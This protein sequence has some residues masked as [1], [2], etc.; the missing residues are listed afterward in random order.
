MGATEA[1]PNFLQMVDLFFDKAAKRLN[2]PPNLLA[3]IKT[4]NSMI[5]VNFPMKKKSTVGHA[6]VFDVEVIQGYRA[7]HSH[8]RVPCKG[9]IRYATTVD[10]Q[11]V[12]ALAALM[13]FKCATVN[14]PFGGGKG[15]LCID[16][17]KYSVEELEAITR[18]FTVELIKKNSIGCSV[19][20]PAPDYGT[21]AREMAWMRDTYEIF[22]PDDLHGAACVTG[23]PMDHGG[24]AGR[25]EATGLGVFF[26]VEEAMSKADDME[27]LGLTTGIAG[28]T[29][30]VQGFGNVGYWSAVHISRNGGIV[31]GI[32]EYNGAI[33]NEKGINVEAAGK[34][35]K[36]RRTFDGLS[37]VEM[38]TPEMAMYR[39]C[40]VLV[41]AALE[42]VVNRSNASKLSCKIVAEAANGPVTPKAAEILEEKGVLIIPDLFLNAGGVT[43]SYFEWLQNLSHVNFGRLQRRYNEN[44][45]RRL[46]DALEDATGKEIP[47]ALRKSIERTEGKS[48]YDIVCSGLKETMV[49]AYNEIRDMAIKSSQQEGLGPCNLRTA[50]FMCSIDKIVAAYKNLGIFP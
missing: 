36:E 3:Q 6:D 11:E 13:T 35:W 23:K 39:S 33:Y 44:S 26:G 31:T 8:H 22:R 49:V 12:K 48:E 2:H 16:T 28:K 24:I 25:E 42:L 10:A 40:D 9:G 17:S 15:G 18:R 5:E 41:P 37:D 32:I 34:Y 30:I 14:V 7:Q 50:A 47:V 46:L 29:F 4:C 43:V 20:V 27:A 19:D 1:E 38:L 45:K 21:G